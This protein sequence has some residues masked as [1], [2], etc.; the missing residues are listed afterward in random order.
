MSIDSYLAP[1]TKV[2]SRW[3]I[4]LNMKGKM[5]KIV[6]DEKHSRDVGVDKDFLNRTQYKL[7]EKSW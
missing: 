5:I 3:I 1:H 2:N 4:D 7:L 6:K